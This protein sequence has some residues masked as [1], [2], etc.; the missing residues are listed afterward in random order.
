MDLVQE[1]PA[2]HERTVANIIRSIISIIELY[3]FRAATLSCLLRIIQLTFLHGIIFTPG[4]LQL[5]NIE[6][7]VGLIM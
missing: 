5:K 3:S 6:I 2:N 7:G 1:L 4:G